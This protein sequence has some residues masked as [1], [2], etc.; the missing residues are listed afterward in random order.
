MQTRETVVIDLEMREDAAKLMAE[1]LKI[2]SATKIENVI[3]RFDSRRSVDIGSFCFEKRSNGRTP[4]KVLLDSYNQGRAERL[5]DFAVELI[6]YAFTRNV[7]NASSKMAQFSVMLHWAEAN[8]HSDFLSSPERY[9]D[10]T[11]DF[12]NYL[13][14]SQRHEGS[15]DYLQRGALATAQ[16]IFP[17]SD[18][19]F[20]S[21]MA[22]II[23]EGRGTSK[24]V[25][26]TGDIREFLTVL[27]ALFT[28]LTSFLI[29]HEH[30]PYQVNLGSS[31]AMLTTHAQSF[32]S[33]KILE[34]KPSTGRFSPIANYAD[35][36]WRRHEDAPSYTGGRAD[37]RKRI[38]KFKA[39]LSA[40]NTDMRHYKR[41][42][43]AK[44]AHD[45]FVGIFAAASGL[46]EASIINIE[47]TGEFE[48][49]KG[50]KGMR[51]LT[52]MKYRGGPHIS[53]FSMHVSFF[54]VFNQYLKLREY[55]LNGAEHAHLFIGLTASGD[56]AIQKLKRTT[57][58]DLCRF[59]KLTVDPNFPKISYRDLRAY[60]DY[61]IVMKSGIKI[62]ASILQHS[63]K[64][65]LSNYTGI[66]EKN[67][68]DQIA[69]ALRDFTQMFSAGKTNSVPGGGCAEKQAS[70][71]QAPPLGYEPDCKNQTGCIYCIHFRTT[72][73]RENIRKLVGM[74]YIIKQRIY[75]CDNLEHFERNHQPALDR[76][77]LIF[78]EMKKVSVE[79]TSLL[80]EIHIEFF[81]KKQ[82]TDY[83]SRHQQ[84]L[85][86]SGI[87]K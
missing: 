9:H 3:L 66:N 82:L 39:M 43:L 72:V 47:W 5:Y 57:I 11:K 12:T 44:T 52:V 71:I 36:L 48:T 38:E 55:I 17:D 74:K 41:L 1:S 21:G 16:W 15:K 80:D 29:S 8:N 51:T 53:S 61:F 35:G 62:A 27:H 18:T 2:L 56:G 85:V 83:W 79:A 75:N 65:Q 25:S 58:I 59:L 73:D 30:F 7:Q 26:S 81:D 31:I 24:S 40:A 67:A 68:I 87:F 10:A 22:H 34:G 45:C 23:R 46:N 33:D 4:K 70:P 28:Q 64:I 63:E 60:K 32:L 76:I 19:E 50:K 14:K 86:H 6:T 13:I 77:Q 37:Y 69:A 42:R 84:N 78:S 54:S 20:S 49:I